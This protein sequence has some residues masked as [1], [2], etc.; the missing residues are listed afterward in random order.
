MVRKSAE[1]QRRYREKKKLEDPEYREREVRRVQSY[2]IPTSEVSSEIVNKRRAKGRASMKKTREKKKRESFSAS[3]ATGTV[4][5]SGD[6][7]EVGLS[8]SEVMVPVIND[9]TNGG[10]IVQFMLYLCLRYGT[11]K[12]DKISNLRSS[13]IYLFH[14]S[15]LRLIVYYYLSA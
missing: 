6:S 1:N 8:Y 2:Y 13:R 4:D 14:L 3:D 11:K 9:N 12:Y 10:L 7:P 15:L 5:L